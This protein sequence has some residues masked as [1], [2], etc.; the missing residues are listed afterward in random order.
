MGEV[1]CGVVCK[2]QS[3][4]PEGFLARTGKINTTDRTMK[5]NH[6]DEYEEVVKITITNDVRR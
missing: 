1:E 2:M 4:E 5:D 6:Q 3:G